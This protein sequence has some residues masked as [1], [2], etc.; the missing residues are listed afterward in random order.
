M[1][2]LLFLALLGILLGGAVWKTQNPDGNVTDFRNQTLSTVDRLK[3][4]VDAGVAAVRNQ[5]GT[6]VANATGEAKVNTRLESLE[7]KLEESLNSDVGE[8]QELKELVDSELA[9]TR[10]KVQALESSS[11]SL[12]SSV[13]SLKGT[14]EQ[15]TDKQELPQE[16]PMARIDALETKLEKTDA[17]NDASIVRLDAIDRRL[18]L[19]VRRLDEQT[20]ADDLQTLTDTVDELQTEIEKLKTDSRTEQARM[21]IDI[22][23]VSERTDNL[24]LRINTFTGSQRNSNGDN[25]GDSESAD[26]AEDEPRATALAVSAGLDDRLTSLEEKVANVNA[27]SN[28][29]SALTQQLEA[30][31]Q[32]II[33]LEE[34]N[35]AARRSM[36]N[37]N[38]TIEE[39]QTAGVSL[40]IETVQDEITEQ[41]SQ[42]LTQIENEENETDNSQLESLL[43]TTRNRLKTLEQRVQE[44]PAS[45]SEADAALQMQSTLQ[46]QIQQLERRL[47]DVSKTD[48]ALEITVQDV[49]ERVDRL[50][51]RQ[52]SEAIEYKIYFQRNSAEITDDASQ[53]LNSFI[54][55]EQN[56]TVGVSIFGFT[57]RSGTAAY[58]QQ[59]ALQRATNVRSY[60]IQNGL[61]YTKIKALSG[62]GEDAAAAVLPDESADA[63]QRV[64]VLYAEQP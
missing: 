10:T 18:E 47:E 23:E 64:V 34:Q 29:V 17:G 63:E 14:L 46:S 16:L 21:A 42:A 43:Q 56:R 44:L 38:S 22:A 62:L 57:D 59:L 24:G 60:L 5:G 13:D 61:D 3:T 33:E 52:N 11:N 40:S 30:A 54:T 19:L 27:E 31:E 36:A 2:K 55:Q 20:V 51:A 26:N 7:L 45:S 53:V 37:V 12:Q 9:G 41:L 48:P 4:G 8:N 39:L 6:L 32:K 1:N 15:M 35:A 49:K 25:Q 58:N 50:S 28:R